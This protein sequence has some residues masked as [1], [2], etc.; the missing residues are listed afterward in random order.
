MPKFVKLVAI[1][2]VMIAIAG[3]S[4]A[5]VDESEVLI[6]IVYTVDDLPVFKD[7]KDGTVFDASI[8]IAHLQATVEPASW[9]SAGTGEGEIMPFDKNNSLVVS[10]TQ[11]NH[12]KIVAVLES[13]KAVS[14]K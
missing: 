8:L 7:S 14:K 6:R 5:A 11:S 2:A 12:E 13:L 3:I 4:T 1:S 10:Q 9:M